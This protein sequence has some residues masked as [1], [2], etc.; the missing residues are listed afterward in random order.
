MRK[1]LFIAGLLLLSS[2]SFAQ[3]NTLPY[4]QSFDDPFAATGT[5]AVIY[6]SI[7]G[8]EV[9]T[10]GSRISRDVTNY[11]S[12]PA[13][14]SV[15][16]TGSFQGKVTMSLD[17][18][19]YSSVTF[20]FVMKAMKNSTGTRP[21]KL[22]VDTSVDGT[23]V[24][25]YAVGEFPN[26]DQSGFTSYTYN[27]PSTTNNQANV[28][29]IIRVE[30]GAGGT[31]TRAKIVLDD[32]S[33]IG[34]NLGIE[35]VK[36]NS[37]AEDFIISPNPVKQGGIAYFSKTVDIEVFDLSAKKVQSAKGVSSLNVSGYTSGIYIIKTSK[38]VSKKLIIK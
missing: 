34:Q 38:G 26:A 21:T 36:S 9:A 19:N 4:T 5:P 1:N 22:I 15:I 11:N 13:A 18:T 32:F 7:T 37:H 12:G 2:L 24:D 30:D 25:S 31:G 20:S 28:N 16:P 29:L 3:I 33:I 35:D 8:N 10:D 17:L 6:P 27:L 23:V 14:L